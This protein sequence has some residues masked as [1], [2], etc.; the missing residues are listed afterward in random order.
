MSGVMS[1]VG[2]EEPRVYWIR[3]AIVAVVLLALVI[4]IVAA[5]NAV[6]NGGDNAEGDPAAGP[7]STGPSLQPAD[8]PT[9]ESA[10]PSVAPTESPSD[11]QTPSGSPDASGSESSSPAS[12]SSSKPAGPVDCDGKDVTVAI[13]GPG[14]V[15][16]GKEVSLKVTLTN[17]G[18][19]ECKLAVNAETYEMRIFS[20]TDRIWSTG[21]CERWVK[22][23][24]KT[25]KPKES[26]SFDQGWRVVRSKGCDDHPAKLRPGTYAANAEF[27]GAKPDQVVMQLS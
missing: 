22:K 24:D 25:L 27:S 11:G 17:S 4:T 16:I 26:V 19:S 7:T 8:T 18:T 5:V 21:G 9:P 2:P 3:R 1:P 23:I 6:A 13:D 14:K 10:D 15:S 20:G 12:P